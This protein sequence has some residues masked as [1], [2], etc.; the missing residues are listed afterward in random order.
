MNI[1]F[2][3]FVNLETKQDQF[4]VSF[5]YPYMSRQDFFVPDLCP[6]TAKANRNARIT[7][8]IILIYIDK[9]SIDIYLHKS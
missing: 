8:V 5:S 2:V 4:C 6:V 7:W 3:G 9:Q 1:F